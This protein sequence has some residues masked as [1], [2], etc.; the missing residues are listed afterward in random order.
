V[1]NDVTRLGY[2]TVPVDGKD[3]LARGID[4]GPMRRK[5]IA[6][7]QATSMAGGGKVVAIGFSPFELVV[8]PDADHGFSHRSRDFRPADTADTADTLTRTQERLA[9]LSPLQ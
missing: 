8:Y 1:A 7:A 4:G 3:I 9:Q 6:D 2:S 5:V